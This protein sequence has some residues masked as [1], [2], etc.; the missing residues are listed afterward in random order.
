MLDQETLR[1]VQ[2]RELDMLLEMKRICD[3]HGLKYYLCGGTLLGAVRHKGFIPWDDDI[4]ITMLRADYERFLQIAPKEISSEY[5]VESARSDPNY[6][7]S[8]CKIRANGTVY[9]EECTSKLDMHQ[10]IWIDI[11]PLDDIQGVDYTVLDKRDRRIKFWQT[12]VDHQAKIITLHK[13]TSRLFFS[14]LGAL[15]KGRLM[16]CKEKVLQEGNSAHP[17]HVIDYCDIYGY[18]KTI[19]PIEMYLE[20][21]TVEFEGHLFTTVND[22]DRYLTQ[23]YGDYMQPPPVEKRVSEHG[24]IRCEV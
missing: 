9:M 18:R 17:T 21:A 16:A 24:I 10:G 7:Y 14:L 12:A 6:V 23:I 5:Y 2:L 4:D 8:F 1:K 15:K 11:F 3:R 19:F 22:P 13:P 20:P